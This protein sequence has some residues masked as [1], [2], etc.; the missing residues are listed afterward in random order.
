TAY[1]LRP[2]G[3]GLWRFTAGNSVWTTPAFMGSDSS[4]WGS[5]DFHIYRLGSSGQRLWSTFVPGYVV[6][7]PAI[8]SDGTI[9]VGAFD[10]KLYAVDPSTG[11]IRWSFPT[12]DHIYS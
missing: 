1:A 4:I 3:A 10:A 5:L 12:T 9:Y 8:G 2:D 11:A 6:S 7:S